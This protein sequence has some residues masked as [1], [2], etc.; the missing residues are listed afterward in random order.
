[1][2]ALFGATLLETVLWY[3]APS[4]GF[5]LGDHGLL[6][7]STVDPVAAITSDM[8]PQIITIAQNTAR[9]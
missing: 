4:G 2:R 3:Q 7:I 9:K 6:N 8:A 5:E 1:M